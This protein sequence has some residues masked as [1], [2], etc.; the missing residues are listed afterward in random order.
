[1]LNYLFISFAFGA[2]LAAFFAPCSATLLPGYV[3][4]YISQKNNS[5]TP[6]KKLTTATLFSLSAIL[7]FFTLFGV[8]GTLVIFLGHQVK[9][10]IPYI[11][12]FF[13]IFL[14]ALGIGMLFKKNLMLNLHLKTKNSNAYVFGL[15]YGAASLGCTFPLFITVIL[16]GIIDASIISGFISLLA[17]I[18]G[19]SILMFI[20]TIAAALAQDLIQKYINKIMPYI[21]K[22]SALILIIAGIYMLYYQTLF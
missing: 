19:L 9:I 8:F 20:T 3:T 18:L 11:A 13:G 12:I 6:L 4:Y 22:I 17:Y 21:H 7:G 15:A 5:K 16:Q 10:L 2:G 14:I 1:M